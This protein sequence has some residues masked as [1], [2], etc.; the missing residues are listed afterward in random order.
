M[1]KHLYECGMVPER[2]GEVYESIGD[3][4]IYLKKASC[5]ELDKLTTEQLVSIVAN[6]VRADHFDN[7]FLI[8]TAIAKGLLA[9]YLDAILK[10]WNQHE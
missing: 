9:H 10:R 8:H 7:G 3:E 2:Y 4:G 1:Q 5:H 6:L